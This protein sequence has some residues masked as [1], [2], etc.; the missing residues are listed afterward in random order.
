MK[1]RRT[2]A[3]AATGL[4]VALVLVMLLWDRDGSEIPTV[5][6]N[7]RGTEDMSIGRDGASTDTGAQRLPLPPTATPFDLAAPVLAAHAQAGN[8]R[9]AC[10]LAFELLRCRHSL[11]MD[12]LRHLQTATAEAIASEGDIER[13]IQAD[14]ATLRIAE[15]AMVCRKVDAGLHEQANDFLVQ[16]A[17]ARIPYAMYLYGTGEHIQQDPG[18][19]AR[20]EFDAWRRTAPAMMI[21]ARDAGIPDA[22]SYLAHAYSNEWPLGAAMFAD[23]PVQ[24]NA[25]WHLM[26]LLRSGVPGSS[27]PYARGLDADKEDASLQLARRLHARAYGGRIYP[28]FSG[29]A[30]LPYSLHNP[31]SEPGIDC[32]GPSAQGSMEAPR[33]A[34]D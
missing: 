4:V 27:H 10:R 8:A 29:Y 11:R 17:N 20:P 16:A 34:G 28:G 30:A 3:W 7:D 23:D 24:A 21:A 1:R 5:T 12:R 26:S 22:A 13:A 2:F 6:A 31:T 32:Q 9:A 14:E 25:H 18:F 15:S 33:Q 19:A